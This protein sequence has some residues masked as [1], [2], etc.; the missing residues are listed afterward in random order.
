MIE[1]TV[2]A[3]LRFARHRYA[4]EESNLDA[5]KLYYPSDDSCPIHKKGFFRIIIMLQV[6]NMHCG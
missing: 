4:D 3:E 5:D 1:N 2:Q 6:V